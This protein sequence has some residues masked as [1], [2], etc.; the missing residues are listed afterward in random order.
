[1][2]YARI[3]DGQIVEY[4]VFQGDIRLRFP[5][6]AFGQGEY[7][8]APDGYV[9]VVDAPAP[10]IDLTQD[11]AEGTPA[12]VDGVWTRQWVVTDAAPDAAEERFSKA[13]EAKRQ[14]VNAVRRRMENAVAPTPF[15]AVECDVDSRGKINGAAVMAMLAIQA[16]QPFSINWTMADNSVQALNAQEMIALGQA[17][18]AYIAGLHAIGSAKKAAVDACSSVAELQAMDVDEGWTL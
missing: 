7:F 13:K 11:L 5:L 12:L 18:G 10:G 15:G 9:E 2:T 17:V 14:A 6:C 3:E 4:P 8:E 16:G 1:M